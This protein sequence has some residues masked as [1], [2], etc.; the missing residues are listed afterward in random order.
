MS[1]RLLRRPCKTNIFLLLCLCV[2]LKNT[3]ASACLLIV[4][5]LVTYLSVR[6]LSLQMCTHELTKRFWL[7]AVMAPISASILCEHV[8]QEMP[9][10]IKGWSL[11][12]QYIDSIHIGN[13]AHLDTIQAVLVEWLEPEWSS[14]QTIGYRIF[15]LGHDAMTCAAE[16]H[17]ASHG[18]QLTYVGILNSTGCADHCKH[19][20]TVRCWPQVQVGRSTRQDGVV[21]VIT[22]VSTK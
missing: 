7:T 15:L 3:S 11:Q 22:P 17:I 10:S 9:W 21:I 19:L 13:L 2:T 16:N 4:P 8:L 20:D 6:V 5:Q 12:K 1:L 18:C 14:I